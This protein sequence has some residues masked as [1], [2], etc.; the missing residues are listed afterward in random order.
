MG[1]CVDGGE[2][3]EAQEA[4]GASKAPQALHH[5]VVKIIG[6]TLCRCAPRISAPRA[7]D[8]RPVA[9]LIRAPKSLKPRLAAR[10][11]RGSTNL[12]AVECTNQNLECTRRIAESLQF[13]RVDQHRYSEESLSC[14]WMP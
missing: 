14:C 6:V 8:Y 12:H 9:V 7:R 11:W 2:A 10:C 4:S 5:K 1:A 13:V 3:T